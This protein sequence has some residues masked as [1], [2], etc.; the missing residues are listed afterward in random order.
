MKISNLIKCE[1]IKSFSCKKSIMIFL[2]LVLLSLLFIKTETT[3]SNKDENY[4]EIVSEKIFNTSYKS[5]E[6]NY[7]N[8]PDIINKSMYETIKALKQQYNKIYKSNNID[9]NPWYKTAVATLTFNLSREN[10]MQLLIENYQSD[11]ITNVLKEENN[12]ISLGQLYCSIKDSYLNIFNNYANK[13]IIDITNEKEKLHKANQLTIEALNKN[14]YYIYVEYECLNKEDLKKIDNKYYETMKKYC[15]YFKSKKIKS[16]NDYRSLNIKQ[17]RALNN[18]IQG[19]ENTNSEKN[20]LIKKYYI[21]ESKIIEYAV[22]NDLKHDIKFIDLEKDL[23]YLTTKNITNIGLRFGAIVLI[24]M[25]IVNAGIISK[26]HSTGTIKLV[27]TK[28]VSR[29]TIIIAKYLYLILETYIWWIISSI[30]IGTIAGINYGFNDLFTPK[31]I[32]ANNSV[33]E[34]NYIVWYFKEMLICSIPILC[35]LSII[36]FLS[37]ITLS[38]SL[39]TSLTSITSAFSMIIWYLMS[40]LSGSNISFIP[41]I[42]ISYIDYYLIRT[43]HISYIDVI[44]HTPLNES[45]GLIICTITTILLLVLTTIIYKHKDIKA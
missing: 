37:T 18:L 31:L 11:K 30:I 5:I 16:E 43:H 27:L 25:S 44:S 42:P 45:Y 39:T 2:I 17:F 38:T 3:Q 1:F 12:C 28:P 36:T 15:D 6:S 19:I 8:N 14:E 22:N 4:A 40:S 20:Q 24:I 32:M 26:E 29:T 10:A 33:K 34:I 41:Y 23:S 13:N 21:E 35:M 7:K 9:D